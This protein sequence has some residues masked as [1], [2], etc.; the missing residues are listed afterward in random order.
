MESLCFTCDN[1]HVIK[2]QNA[3]PLVRCGAMFPAITIPFEVH[4]CDR[5]EPMYVPSLFEMER[6]AHILV[7][8]NNK[9]VGFQPPKRKGEE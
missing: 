2:G 6:I 5:H 7:V 9:I 1:A 4:E 3:T 8:K